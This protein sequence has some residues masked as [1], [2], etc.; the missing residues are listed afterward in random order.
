MWASLYFPDLPL[1]IFSRGSDTD[2]DQALVITTGSGPQ[3][4]LVAGNAL[5]RAQGLLP[6]MTLSA[7]YALLPSLWVQQRNNA[8]E[9]QALEQLAVWAG[10][11]TSLVN[12]ALPDALLLEIG[13]SLHLFGGMAALNRKIAAEVQEL[14]YHSILAV[15]PTP[16]GALWL[17]R[18]R[19][20]V[21]ID[22]Q[23]DLRTALCALP[24]RSLDM[25]EK[26][27]T[28]LEAIGMRNIDDCLRLPRAGLARRF[29]QTLLNDLDKAL[30]KLPDPR[31]PFVAPAQFKS[32]LLLPVDVHNS[33]ALLFAA[34]RLLLEL[35]AFLLARD[36]GIQT[37]HLTL[38]HRQPPESDMTIGL[39]KPAR[40]MAH[41]QSL[42][43]TRLEQEQLRE[44]VQ[45]LTLS[46]PHIMAMATKTRPLFHDGNEEQE[47]WPVLLE[48]LRARLGDD[49]VHGIW[50]AAEHRPEYAWRY[51]APG[52]SGPALSTPSR[53]LWLL[54]DPMPLK[55]V[56]Q[57]P[58]FAGE[59]ILQQGPERIESGWW[60]GREVQRDY[61]I[62]KNPHGEHLWVFRNHHEPGKWFL[63]GIFG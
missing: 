32:H 44:P 11:F 42:L 22:N 61:F 36:A 26:T 39:V 16:L 31:R 4:I 40:D 57:R 20:S 53:P 1:E 12:L 35:H 52:E 6:G 60:D 63:H 34:R 37:M 29:G 30:G 9:Q 50:T 8:A 24:L 25:P 54:P 33:E 46:A 58:W 23:Q 48:K 5:A 13:G 38:H 45:E 18:N 62:A 3:Q 51:C 17:S 59:L 49:A 7:A 56:R 14:G 41:L 28:A 15:A 43:K 2:K 55:Q 19:R 27:H 10:Q 47:S 21:V